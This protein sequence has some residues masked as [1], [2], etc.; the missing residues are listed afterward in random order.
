MMRLLG[1]AVGEHLL[2]SRRVRD[3]RQDF[4]EFRVGLQQ[5]AVH[6]FTAVYVIEGLARNH[7]ADV[8]DVFFRQILFR[9]LK[10]AILQ[11]LVKPLHASRMTSYAL[12]TR[13]RLII[14]FF[15]P[16][17]CHMRINLRC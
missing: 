11:H 12:S 8:L 2:E 10:L 14:N 4:L 1:F 6:R 7:R 13:V 5:H 9:V 15:Q 3:D 16:L 17:C